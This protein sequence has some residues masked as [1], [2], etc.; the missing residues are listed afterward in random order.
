[1]LDLQHADGWLYKM[2]GWDRVIETTEH[3]PEDVLA[4]VLY[5]LE[6]RR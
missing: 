6:H 2:V 1:M 4:K 5:R 3:L